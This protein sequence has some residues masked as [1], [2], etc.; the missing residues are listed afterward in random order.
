VRAALLG[1]FEGF[2]LRGSSIEP[3]PRLEGLAGFVEHRLGPHPWDEVELEPV[4]RRVPLP[5][6]PNN[7]ANSSPSQ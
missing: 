2:T 6:M 4:C 7:Y 3:H 1:I 5:S